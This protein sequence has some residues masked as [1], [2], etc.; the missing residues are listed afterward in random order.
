[1]LGP[2]P[3]EISAGQAKQEEAQARK[4]AA[5]EMLQQAKNEAST[6]KLT[7]DNLLKEAGR[8]METIQERRAEIASE[9]KE[10]QKALREF[11][12]TKLPK[13]ATELE[14][15]KAEAE[16]YARRRGIEAKI[17]EGQLA[18]RDR[19]DIFQVQQ[20]G[21]ARAGLLGASAYGAGAAY[22]SVLNRIEA[23]TARTAYNTGNHVVYQ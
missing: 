20:A 18:L 5:A 3:E 15:V 13:E 1:M 14:R 19:K 9:L 12:T 17:K 10:N 16:D 22:R 11:K 8:S 23:N 2:T 21:Y 6:K 7:A 4:D